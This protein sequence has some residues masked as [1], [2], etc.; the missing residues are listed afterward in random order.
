MKKAI[1]TDY[2]SPRKCLPL[3][4]LGP[5][6][7][8]LSPSRIH[9][10][11]VGGNT[12]HSGHIKTAHPQSGESQRSTVSGK[13]LESALLTSRVV[14]TDFMADRV[15]GTRHDIRRNE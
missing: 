13:F 14:S 6:S 8:H 3:G 15:V 10:K 12:T 9:I 2:D 1:E 7:T 11:A 5:G 4:D